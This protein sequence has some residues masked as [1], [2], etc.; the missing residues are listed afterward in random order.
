MIRRRA[1][2]FRCTK[3]GTDDFLISWT[4]DRKIGKVRRKVTYRQFTNEAAAKRFCRRHKIDF[5]E[6]R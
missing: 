4:F 2:D 3:R 5:R 6:A 1:Y